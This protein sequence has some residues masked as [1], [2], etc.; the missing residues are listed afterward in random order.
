MPSGRA[1]RARRHTP[2]AP[3]RER[4]ASPRVLVGAAVVVVVAAFAV[5]L[6]IALTGSSKK[7]AANVPAVGSLAT[8]LPGA[9]EVH[10]L[11]AGIPQSGTRLGSPSAPVTLTEYVDLQCPYCQAFDTQVLP[12]VVTRYVRTGKVQVVLRVWAFV[13]PDS[14]RGQSAVLAAGQQNKAFDLAQVLYDNQGTENTGWLSSQ[15]VVSAAASV[16]GLRVPQLLAAQSSASVHA[17]AASVDRLART[18]GVRSTPTLFVG[19]SGT[20][21]SVVH[22]RSPTDTAT[23][24]R[25]I[26]AAL[27]A[28][29]A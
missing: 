28:Q 25:A 18:D 24:T 10:A 29:Q 4:R 9:D 6:G 16:P 20:H 27:K 17:Q 19:K 26:D 1:S 8:A 21:G 7:P 13:G 23:I 5:A 14:F 12:Q 15:M 2:A 22:L 3:V 11:L